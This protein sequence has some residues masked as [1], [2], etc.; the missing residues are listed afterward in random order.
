MKSCFRN[1]FAFVVY[2]FYFM[3]CLFISKGSYGP[4][5][6]RGTCTGQVVRLRACGT[7][8]AKIMKCHVL[9]WSAGKV[10]AEDQNQDQAVLPYGYSLTKTSENNSEAG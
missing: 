1:G 9:S 5:T 6:C 8:K 2:S 4:Y 7:M 3:G 10:L